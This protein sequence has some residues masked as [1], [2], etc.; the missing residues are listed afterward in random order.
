MLIFSFSLL[1]RHQALNR[2]PKY[3]QLLVKSS[4]ALLCTNIF[5]KLMHTAPKKLHLPFQRQETW[6]VGYLRLI[7]CTA[8]LQF[9]QF[10]AEC[11][12]TQPSSSALEQMDYQ[13]RCFLEMSST[14]FFIVLICIWIIV[15]FNFFIDI[16]R[17]EPPIPEVLYRP[18]PDFKCSAASFN[19]PSW[20][21]LCFFSTLWSK[22]LLASKKI[23]YVSFLFE[24][25]R[26]TASFCLVNH[27]TKILLFRD[28]D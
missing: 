9:Y 18:H 6:R 27:N 3:K 23:K 19:T 20:I 21:F 1:F 17:G 4:M 12:F 22:S 16:F 25:I 13:R 8:M 26:F 11:A 5:E 10:Q 14:Y 7:Y 15:C 2:T 28:C 24:V